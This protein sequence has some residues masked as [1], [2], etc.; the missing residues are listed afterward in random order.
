VEEAVML[1]GRDFIRH[2][3]TNHTL[4]RVAMV[5]A[6][7]FMLVYALFAP[8]ESSPTIW[9]PA[10]RPDPLL[11]ASVKIGLG[12]YLYSDTTLSLWGDGSKLD[13]TADGLYFSEDTS[14]TAGDNDIDIL[15]V[16][17]AADASPET[18][19]I[20]RLDDVD[21]L[22]DFLADT[23]FGALLTPDDGGEVAIFNRDVSASAVDGT[24]QG[25]IIRSDTTDVLSAGATADGSGGVD[26]VY[27]QFHGDVITESDHYGWTGSWVNAESDTVKVENGIIWDVVSP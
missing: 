2:R 16:V 20:M 14:R 15:S 19:L 6:G 27:V 22:I 9:G 8:A 18:T 12:S 13:V 26:S 23:R 10:G 3:L 17:E 25:I 11:L 24:R 4:P 1:T 21:D 7:L 5:I